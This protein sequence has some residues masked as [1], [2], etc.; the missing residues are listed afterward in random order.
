MTVAVD[1][2][3]TDQLPAIAAFL[4]GVIGQDARYISHGEIQAGLSTHGETWVDD[5]AAR[6][7]VDFRSLDP[8]RRV[9]AAHDPGGVLVGA[10]VVLTVDGPDAAYV[11]IEDVAVDPGARSHGVGG[12]LIAF[13]EGAAREAGAQWAFLESG[14]DNERA[15]AFFER[16][17]YRPL[18]KVFGKRL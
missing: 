7:A 11:V 6:F 2:A 3:S 12:A 17:A 16:Q 14:L 1:W 18:S 9:V 10:A 4:S 8:D 15:H 13:I 5:L